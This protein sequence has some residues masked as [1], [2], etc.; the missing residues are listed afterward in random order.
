MAF[1]FIMENWWQIVY[2]GPVWNA[3]Y[4]LILSSDALVQTQ[5][6]LYLDLWLIDDPRD[7]GEGL[8]HTHFRVWVLVIVESPYCD[9]NEIQNSNKSIVLLLVFMSKCNV[10]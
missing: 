1:Y 7:A 8:F 10:E 5:I 3:W 6:L 2:L 4:I 9:K